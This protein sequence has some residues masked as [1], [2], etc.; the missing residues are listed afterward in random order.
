MA[1]LLQLGT[2]RHAALIAGGLVGLGSDLV[3]LVLALTV[4]QIAATPT[5]LVNG[6]L[7]GLLL[8][9]QRD[10]TDTGTEAVL[11]HAA[12]IALALT[13]A[14]V[15]CLLAAGPAGLTLA[16]GPTGALAWPLLLCL[17]PGIV[18]NSYGGPAARALALL[19]EERAYMQVA[20]LMAV[21]AVPLY[22]GAAR[23]GPIGLVAAVSVVTM[24]ENAVLVAMVRHRLGLRCEARLRLSFARPVA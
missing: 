9:A 12:G 3:A 23:F 13:C 24:I 2:S 14:T 19:G 22:L 8:K 16:F 10:G 6:A 4:A 20:A 7:P 1:Q 18:A 5:T 15:L 17:I 21:I 11:R